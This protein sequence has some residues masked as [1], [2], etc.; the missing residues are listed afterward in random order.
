MGGMVRLLLTLAG[1]GIKASKASKF[2]QRRGK[3]GGKKIPAPLFDK[4]AKSASAF[5]KRRRQ[6]S[7]A[8]RKKK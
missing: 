1:M 7:G 4:A 6:I 8:S 2:L 5:V 3:L